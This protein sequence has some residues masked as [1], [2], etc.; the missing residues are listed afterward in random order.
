MEENEKNF[1]TL[2]ELKLRFIPKE[3][4]MAHKTLR[5]LPS[6]PYTLFIE[7]KGSNSTFIFYLTWQFGLVA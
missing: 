6:L 2:S 7:N 5:P 4:A 1:Q 3:E